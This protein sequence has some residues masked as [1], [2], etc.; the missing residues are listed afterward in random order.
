MIGAHTGVR[1][2]ILARVVRL[3]GLDVPQGLT[4]A[5]ADHARHAAHASSCSCCRPWLKARARSAGVV[6]QR[7]AH[8]RIAACHSRNP[9]VAH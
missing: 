1:P 2:S 7:M 4:W 3:A 9:T 8:R 6:V 5:L